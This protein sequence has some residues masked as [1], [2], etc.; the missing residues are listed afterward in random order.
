[1]NYHNFGQLLTRKDYWLDLDTQGK[2]L[3]NISMESE[4][5]DIRF[6]FGKSFR[7]LMRTE[8]EM[9]SMI[10][11]KVSGEGGSKATWGVIY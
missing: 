4:R 7:T 2:L 5:D 6:H 11:D 9:I 10:V 1:M 8:A 3:V